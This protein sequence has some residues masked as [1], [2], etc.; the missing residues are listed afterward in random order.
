MNVLFQFYVFDAIHRN[1]D[2]ESLLGKGLN[3]P[4]IAN[5]TNR[6]F[7]DQLIV[8]ESNKIKLTAEGIKLMNDLERQIKNRKKSEWIKIEE[9][10][11]APRQEKNFIFVPDQSKLHL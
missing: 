6:G 2:V 11:T 8:Y 3:Y 10:S 7:V 9:G 1:L 4:D 5:I